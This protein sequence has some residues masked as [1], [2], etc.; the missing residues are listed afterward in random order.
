[1]LVN[2]AIQLSWDMTEVIKGK[3]TNY[4]KSVSMPRS[5]QEKPHVVQSLQIVLEQHRE[6]YRYNFVIRYTLYVL[7][8][9]HYAEF[10]V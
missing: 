4:A 5:F 1:M 7:F 9:L 2:K 6:V 3:N 8:D 10:A